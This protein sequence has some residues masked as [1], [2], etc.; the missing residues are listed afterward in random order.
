MTIAS[1]TALTVPVMPV[2]SEP[3]SL[4]SARDAEKTKAAA[5]EFEAV[6]IGQMLNHMFEG[7][8]KDPMF[9]GGA[10][11]DMFRSMLI[12]EYGKKM[13]SGKG[14]GISDQMQKMMIQMQQQHQS[15]Q[16]L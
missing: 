5:R 9:G 13:A 15:L 14:I 7:V 16:Q 12:Q 6:F 1:T 2:Q 10:G 3:T 11:E 4:G 8:G